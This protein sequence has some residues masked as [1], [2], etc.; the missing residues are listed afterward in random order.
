MLRPTR[1]RLV[2]EMDIVRARRGCN[3]IKTKSFPVHFVGISAFALREA[4]ADWLRLEPSPR[5]R[6]R[7]HFLKKI[8]GRWRG[9][10][11]NRKTGR[12][13]PWNQA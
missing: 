9:F 6:E 2:T 11:R 12:G 7:R 10:N 4:I 5:L 8:A 3:L 1:S 13:L